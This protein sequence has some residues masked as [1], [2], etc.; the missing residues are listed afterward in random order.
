[1]CLTQTWVHWK[2]DHAADSQFPD[3]YDSYIAWAKNIVTDP[4]YADY[5]IIILTHHFNSGGRD[6]QYGWA[7]ALK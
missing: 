2:Q 3:G 5:N 6:Y 1:M 7:E 4:Q